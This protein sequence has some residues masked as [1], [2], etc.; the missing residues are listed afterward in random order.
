MRRETIPLA[1]TAQVDDAA[2]AAFPGGAGESFRR[3]AFSG[4]KSP[5]GVYG[6]N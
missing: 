5:A 6:L 3:P 4:L 2:H 1:Q